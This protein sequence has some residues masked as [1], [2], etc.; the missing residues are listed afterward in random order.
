M[1]VASK[2]KPTDPKLWEKAKAK[3]KERY[4]I[5]PS[6]YAVGHALKIYK[7]E[8]GGWKKGKTARGKA[9]ITALP[10]GPGPRPRGEGR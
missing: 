1:R 7:D 3:A 6:A 2:N 5:W 4:E 8:G 9:M 10:C